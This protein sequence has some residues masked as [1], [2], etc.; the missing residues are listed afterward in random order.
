MEIDERGDLQ[1]QWSIKGK[2]NLKTMET[3][4]T[5]NDG[6]VQYKSI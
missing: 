5:E 6:I 4:F 1:V 3:S 2:Q